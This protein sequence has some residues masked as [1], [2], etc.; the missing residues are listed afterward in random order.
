M[1][2]EELIE[3]IRQYAE[4]NLRYPSNRIKPSYP[5]LTPD[6]IVTLGECL[7]GF[8]YTDGKFSQK[9][10]E[11]LVDFTFEDQNRKAILVNSGSSADLV[12]VRGL[13][14]KFDPNN[15]RQ[16]IITTALSFPTTISAIY[17]NNKIPIYVDV[18]PNTLEPNYKQIKMAFEKEGKSI[19]GVVL[20]HTLGFPYNE[21]EVSEM[22]A[23]KKAFLL[24]DC[25]DALGAILDENVHVGYF[26][27]ASTFSFFPAHH[28]TTGEGG[29][30]IVKDERL[31]AIISSLVNWGR[32]C[33]CIPGASNTCG[34]RFSWPT[35]K[36]PKGWD[37]KYIFDRLGFNLK[38]TEFQAALGFSQIQKA[39]EFISLRRK[40]FI[41]LKR[42]LEPFPIRTVEGK[43]DNI[44]P[45]GFPIYLEDESQ[46]A[47]LIDHL[48]NRG[49][50]TRRMFG[51]NVTYQPGY[52]GLGYLKASLDG[53]NKVMTRMF[54]IGCHP[55]IGKDEIDKI[56]NAFKEFFR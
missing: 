15:K 48:E 22:C 31:D 18:D 47:S 34:Q 41:E 45:F 33:Y 12:A 37:H 38:M 8:W 27:D 23:E 19:C 24:S 43:L 55:L 16:Y 9:F 3:Q 20:T 13:I 36:L 42:R 4:E 50:E 46:V 56:E 39:D 44:S 6:D 28:I 21:F 26:S 2:R 52:M 40:N 11:A 10:R 17:F 7:L 29:A 32:S 35:E 14:E 25:C 1:N 53:T 49:I 5:K 51:G 30:V 54:W